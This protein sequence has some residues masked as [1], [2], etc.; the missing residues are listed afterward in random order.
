MTSFSKKCNL[1]LPVT[2]IYHP[3]KS[4]CFLAIYQIFYTLMSNEKHNGNVLLF[5]HCLLLEM[6]WDKGVISYDFIHNLLSP[7]GAHTHIN[8]T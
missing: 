5:W 4:M 8:K 6:N 2:R 7:E 1:L 3:K